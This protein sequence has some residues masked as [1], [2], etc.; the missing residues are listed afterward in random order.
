MSALH[1]PSHESA[2]SVT[3]KALVGRGFTSDVYDW[4]TGRVL[5]LFHAS[6]PDW[7]VEREFNN[8]RAVH[9]AA[10]PAPAVYEQLEIDGRCGI[11][12]Q[13]IEGISLYRHVQARPWTLFAAVR[14]MAEL[15]AR[16]HACTA[17]SELLTQRQRIETGI[18]AAGDVPEEVKQHARFALEK[19]P[20]GESL[21]HGDFHPENIIL[22]KT[23]PILIDWG[24]AS[25]G[26]PLSDV[27]CTLRLIQ[28]ADL[29]PWVPLHMRLLLQCARS[30][31]YSRYRKHALRL[32]AGTR[33][34]IEEWN[35][36]LSVASAGWGNQ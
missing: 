11:V 30:L 23:G 25:R 33:L 32:H 3:G 13:K 7:K 5:K 16:I 12:F 15:H 4:G 27:A 6:V 35:L 34:E 17:P 9:A 10:L 1:S 2:P 28:I 26:H 22:T 31:I 36:P 18:A 20:D 14:Q 21:C 19:L 8:A 29:P 24:R